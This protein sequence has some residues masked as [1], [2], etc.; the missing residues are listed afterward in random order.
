M[1]NDRTSTG[2]HAVPASPA[3]HH[4]RTDRPVY[5]QSGP[6]VPAEGRDEIVIKGIGAEKGF[7]V[8]HNACKG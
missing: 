3:Q 4:E 2:H 6:A 7:F 8:V 1:P 5:T